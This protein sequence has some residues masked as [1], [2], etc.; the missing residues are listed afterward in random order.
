M[1]RQTL[2]GQGTLGVSV[3]KL[4][5]LVTRG[6]TL[7]VA[8]RDALASSREQADYVCDGVADEGEILAAIK[9]LVHIGGKVKMSEGIFQFSA[10]LIF[11]NA[12]GV[13]V[14]LEGMGRSTRINY[15][16][17]DYVISATDYDGISLLDFD[18]DAGGV[19][20]FGSHKGIAKYWKDGA[21]VDTT[22]LAG[23]TQ[24]LECWFTHADAAAGVVIGSLPHHSLVTEV[25]IYVEEAFNA[26]DTNLISTGGL[27]NASPE[28]A[29]YSLDVDVG[30]IGAKT[31]KAG[32]RLGVVSAEV[33]NLMWIIY[34]GT[35]PTT[36]EALVQIFLQVAPPRP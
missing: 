25:R 1:P 20:I 33:D 32:I 35:T 17:V 15:N 31:L 4:S 6:C 23:E 10:P 18:T 24:V 9:D 19:N 3:P 14:T 21:W 12:G 27:W 16:G 8:S 2:E 30:S 34:T 5:H 11:P 22:T 28:P 29:A 13:Y 26:G 36:G 7:M